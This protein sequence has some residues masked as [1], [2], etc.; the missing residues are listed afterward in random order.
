[1]LYYKNYVDE[2]SGVRGLC[3]IYRGYDAQPHYHPVEELYELVYGEGV[4]YL[5][6]TRKIVKAPYSVWIPANVVHTIKPTS[7]VIILKYYFPRGPFK[8]IEYTW[9]R[10]HSSSWKEWMPSK[11]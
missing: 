9:L 4:M 2:E 8:D 1:M 6:D 10:N 11:L 7:S 5:G 3:A